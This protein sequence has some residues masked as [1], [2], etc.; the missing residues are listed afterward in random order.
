MLSKINIY[1]MYIIYIFYK[2]VLL[3]CATALLP[4]PFTPNIIEGGQCMAQ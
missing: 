1:S 4:K 3:I 2:Y